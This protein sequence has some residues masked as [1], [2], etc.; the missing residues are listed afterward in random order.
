M[1]QFSNFPQNIS[2][3]A[4]IL[5]APLDWGLGH[6]TRCIPLI[7]AL[8]TGYNARITVAANGP[9]KAIIQEAFPGITFLSPPS[10]RIKYHKNRA[11]TVAGLVLAVPGI[12]QKIRAEAQWLEDILARESFDIIIS[13]NRY[14]FAHRTIPS[15]LVTHQ[16]LVKSAFGPAIDR[17]LQGRLYKMVNRF[18]ECWVPDLETEPS[19]AGELSHPRVFPAIPVRYIG[20]LTRLTSPEPTGKTQL[21]VL[22]S[23]PEPQRT[24]FENL[25][26]TQWKRRP[27]KSLVLV[28]GLP[29]DEKQLESLP[30]CRCYNH[31]P[32]DGFSQEVANAEKI[33]CRSGYSSIMDLIP[34]KKN[35]IMVPTPGQTEQEYLAK[36]LGSQGVIK[37]VDQ[38]NLQLD[39]LL[40]SAAALPVC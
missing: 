31:L 30:N 17:L 6:A 24:I 7:E 15:Y 34:L 8:I 21:L 26:V 13:D 3:N 14:G 20:P 11:A 37:A 33:L 22:L 5:V 23:G 32:A 27:G 16:L 29:L 35:C 25:V 19:L 18:T 36:Y 1:T 10:N 38:K 39:E 40:E 4:K 28:R 2:Q 9:Q 12:L